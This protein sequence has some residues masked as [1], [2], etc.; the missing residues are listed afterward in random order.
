MRRQRGWE[1]RGPWYV[2][3]CLMEVGPGM[4]SAALRVSGS[5]VDSG[6]GIETTWGGAGKR[7]RIGQEGVNT[8]ECPV[9][10]D[11]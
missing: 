8:Q 9:Q 3:V 10:E 4:I 1:G 2:L 7:R 5:S 6:G 11:E